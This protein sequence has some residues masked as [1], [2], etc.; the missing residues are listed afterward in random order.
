MLVKG[1]AARRHQP[2]G[3]EATQVQSVRRELAN[4]VVV[5]VRDVQVVELVERES[6]GSVQPCG[7]KVP[8]VDAGR[9]E[10]PNGVD[11]LIGDEQISKM[12]FPDPPRPG[13]C[14]CAIAGLTAVSIPRAR[15]AMLALTNVRFGADMSGSF[16]VAPQSGRQPKAGGPRERARTGN[17]GRPR[18][19]AEVTLPS[20]AQAISGDSNVALDVRD[21]WGADMPSTARK[22]RR[23]VRPT[24]QFSQDWHHHPPLVRRGPNGHSPRACAH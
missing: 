24:A 1:Q 13:D 16:R 5:D 22:I 21:A 19:P 17:R 3:G 7:G 6:G 14:A 9:R 11:G 2:R 10:L 20:A 4:G 8:Q 18:W 15:T 23:R 12:R